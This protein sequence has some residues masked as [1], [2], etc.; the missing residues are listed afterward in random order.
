MSTCMCDHDGS[1][2]HSLCGLHA[3]HV[4]KETDALAARLAEAE[5]L[6]TNWFDGEHPSYTTGEFLGL[7][8]PRTADSADEDPTPW[9]NQC[10]ARK[11]VQCKCG[12]IAEN[13]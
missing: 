7:I 13:E 6:L 10:G 11:Q 12:P 4:R 1:N 2:L 9:C 8:P 5:R 3:N